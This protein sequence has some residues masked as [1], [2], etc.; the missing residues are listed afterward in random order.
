M[1]RTTRTGR[2]CGLT[3]VELLVVLF[4]LGLLAA[5]ASVATAGL[6][7]QGQQDATLRSLAAI[8]TAVLGAPDR[9]DATGTPYVTGFVADV[10]RLPVMRGT[11]A[12]TGLQ[13]LWRGTDGTLSSPATWTIALFG[14]QTPAGDVEVR[15]PAGWRGPYVN[16]PIGTA[17]LRDG[18]RRAFRLLR[19][20][21]SDAPVGTGIEIV[22]SSGADGAPDGA[23]PSA[24]N[25][26]DL[27][28]VFANADPVETVAPRYSGDLVV[29]VRS[30]AGV[31]NA[32]IRIYGPADGVV[33]TLAQPPPQTI[34]AGGQATFVVTGVAI[35]PKI[36]R[37]YAAAAPADP[38]DPFVPVPATSRIQ[39]VVVEAGGLPPIVLD[40]P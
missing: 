35:G 18:W 5:T 29:I 1:K 33:Q 34:P 12:E 27:A 20:D 38:N 2:E 39:P 9:Q 32:S 22:R 15:L 21:G 25:D 19:A 8:E 11:A 14:V 36:L 40:L 23:T 17:Q 28:T 24:G 26:R 31:T 16:T 30:T 7:E 3:L 4:V 13:E 37:A 10:G 6:L